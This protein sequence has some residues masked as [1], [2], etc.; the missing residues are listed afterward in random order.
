MLNNFSFDNYRMFNGNHQIKLKPITIFTGTNNSG[1]SSLIKLIYA[2]LQK[3]KGCAWIDD[4]G[5]ASFWENQHDKSSPQLSNGV[6][7]NDIRLSLNHIPDPSEFKLD[8]WGY[9]NRVASLVKKLANDEEFCDTISLEI[10]LDS[11][12]K[13]IEELPRKSGKPHELSQALNIWSK[14]PVDF[15]KIREIITNDSYTGFSM[16]TNKKSLDIYIS[17]SYKYYPNINSHLLLSSIFDKIISKIANASENGDNGIKSLHKILEYVFY[18]IIILPI[19]NMESQ[20]YRCFY[21]SAFRGYYKND[22]NSYAS[23]SFQNF[24]KKQKII[25]GKMQRQQ[26]NQDLRKKNEEIKSDKSYSK[27]IDTKELMRAR[28]EEAIGYYKLD[29]KEQ[30][31]LEFVKKWVNAF[32]I[33]LEMDQSNNEGTSPLFRINNEFTRRIEEFGFGVQQFFPIISGIATSPDGIFYIEEPESHLHPEFQSKLA[34]FFVDALSFTTEK[35]IDARKQQFLIETHSEYFILK[36]QYL[37]A[38]GVVSP[39]DI[40]LYYIATKDGSST[41]REMEFRKDGILK[42]DFGEGFF[43]ESM[44]WTRELLN[45]KIQN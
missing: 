14:N 34:D 11:L 42:Q 3:F 31:A 35:F 9:E 12:K 37:V 28:M 19:K 30:F 45:L 33:G 2:T 1:K 17:F 8:F 22:P 6:R 40:A 27:A 18:Q 26:K 36:L 43:D 23:L 29:S 20:A 38:K 25:Q 21:L 24:N 10:D 39:D 41:I 32:G 16:M 7:I 44:R 5:Y 13:Y 15:E 4:D